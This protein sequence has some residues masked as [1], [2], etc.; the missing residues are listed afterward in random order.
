MKEAIVAPVLKKGDKSVKENYW[1]V[2]C[3][4]AA[5][6]LLELLVCNQ[7]TEYMES[8]NL[9]PKSQHGFRAQRSTNDSARIW[10]M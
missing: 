3:L 1:P 7:T 10:N 9:L 2:S 5:A 8:N 4:L 6:K